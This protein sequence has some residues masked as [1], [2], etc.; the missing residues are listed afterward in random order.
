VF[1]DSAMRSRCNVG[2]TRE[3]L[4]NLPPKSTNILQ[5]LPQSITML[6]E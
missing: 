3:I 1:D 6:P 5:N 4:P 2:H